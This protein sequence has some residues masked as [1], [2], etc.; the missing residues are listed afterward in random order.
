MTAVP[1]PVP[2]VELNVFWAYPELDDILSFPLLLTDLLP[3][4]KF[5]LLKE[6]F[7]FCII[8]PV[9]YNPAPLFYSA[10]ITIF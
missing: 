4:I 8:G 1:T 7:K 5:F 6:L 10:V 9:D 3:L 2:D